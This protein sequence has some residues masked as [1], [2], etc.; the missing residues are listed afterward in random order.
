MFICNIIVILSSRTHATILFTNAL[1][2]LNNTHIFICVMQVHSQLTQTSG[3]FHIFQILS[4]ILFVFSKPI[5]ILYFE[6]YFFE[7]T[8]L[9]KW[10]SISNI[11]YFL[12]TYV[13]GKYFAHLCSL[14]WT[15]SSYYHHI[16]IYKF[17][18]NT[19]SYARTITVVLRAWRKLYTKLLYHPPP[20]WVGS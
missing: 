9:S 5:H 17:N 19:H 2:K 15:P 1:F 3:V 4:Y 10:K 20:T 18:V 6:K 7:K 12:Y 11:I 8:V 14:N 13:F 16:C